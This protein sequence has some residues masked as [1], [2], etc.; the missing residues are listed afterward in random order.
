MHT[1]KILTSTLCLL[2]ALTIGT[3]Q[4]YTLN[5]PQYGNMQAK[6]PTLEQKQQQQHVEQRMQKLSKLL[7]EMQKPLLKEIAR[8]SLITY[9]NPN[10][11]P[12][13]TST[14]TQQD[15]NAS[16]LPSEDKLTST[17]CTVTD[18][19]NSAAQ[20][21]ATQS[22]TRPLLLLFGADEFHTFLGCLNCAPN[23][24]LSV[25]NPQGPYGSAN[26]QYSIWSTNFEFGNESAHYCPWNAFGRR[27]P[28]IID[29]TGKVHGRLS[30]NTMMAHR[31]TGI[32]ANMLYANY[33]QIRLAPKTWFKDF[34]KNSKDAILRVPETNID[35]NQP[36]DLNVPKS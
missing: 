21:Q 34:F 27:P 9:P 29:T 6:V 36:I 4:A 20:R 28:F 22:T 5:T 10:K 23:E 35:A 11:T 25:W 26:S 8:L 18:S 24:A 31:N 2:S 17:D 19:S 1:T 3:T 33:Q 32:L 7:P 14:D 15:P 13:S 12:T 16:H 30:V